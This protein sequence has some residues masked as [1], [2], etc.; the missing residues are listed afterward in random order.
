MAEQSLPKSFKPLLGTEEANLD[1]KGRI[2]VSKKKRE[3][4][5]DGFTLVQSK[6]GCL[7]AY[8]KEIWDRLMNEHFGFGISN[9][10]RMDYGR[11]MFGTAEDELKFD[12]QGRM[13]VPQKLRDAAKLK[14]KVL[15]IGCGERVE[16]WSASEWEKYNEFPAEYGKDRRAAMEQ[17]HDR[18]RS[19]GQ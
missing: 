6:L 18:M 2:L 15:L 19:V 7:A 16:F 9:D 12:A 1:D 8:P 4:L 13:V 14:D 5:G 11:L 17:A 3:R 10:G